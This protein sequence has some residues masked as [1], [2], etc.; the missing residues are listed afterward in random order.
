MPLLKHENTVKPGIALWYGLASLAV[1]AVSSV[2]AADW[3]LSVQQRL[4]SQAGAEPQQGRSQTSASGLWQWQ[5]QADNQQWG[6]STFARVDAVDEQRSHVDVREAYWLYY[7]EHSEWQLGI[8][9]VFWGVTESAHLVDVINQTDTLEGLDGEDKLGQPML[10]YTRML[11][12]GQWEAFLLPYARTREFAGTDGRLRP[13]WRVDDQ[14]QWQSAAGRQ[15]LDWALRYS[16]S[17]SEVE[18]GLSYF[19]GTAREPWLLA[20]PEAAQLTAYYPQLQQLGVT[21]QYLLGAWLYKL[22]A[23]QR[24]FDAAQTHADPVQRAQLNVLSQRQRAAVVG[25]EYTTVGVFDS[26]YDLGYLVELQYDSR[27]AAQTL[28]QRDL[29]AGLRLAFNDADSSELLAGALWD[30]DDDSYSL[31]VEASIRLSDAS[32]LTLSYNGFHGEANN[33]LMSVSQD[34]VLELNWR[35]YFAN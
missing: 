28:G 7:S 11:E 26:A 27:T 19:N 30:L 34:D 18:L 33:W 25:L 29:F 2:Q 22:E 12:N 20:N 16:A 32:K 21:G 3:E 13:A 1:C 35:W 14:P 5:Q 23:V 17:F 8:A 9:K 10:Q 31:R 6:V 24:H 15:H 4:F